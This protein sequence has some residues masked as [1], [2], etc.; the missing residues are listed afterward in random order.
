MGEPATTTSW[1]EYLA[2]EEASEERHEFI[3]GQVFVMAGATPRHNRIVLNAGNA[4]DRALRDTPCVALAGQQRV[5]VA[6]T[7]MAGYPDVTVVCGPAERLPDQ[8][9]LL[10]PSLLVEVLSPSTED[11]DRGA[12]FRHYRRI[13]SFV[14]YLLIST[15]ERRVEHHRRLEPG[16]WLMREYEHDD[17]RIELPVLGVALTLGDLYDRA[18]ELE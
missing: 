13:P 8:R 10:N 4:L 14:E 1:D 12:K 17:A 3:D 5:F 18:D 16:Q 9:T 11:Y 15:D 2:L 7:G 6:A